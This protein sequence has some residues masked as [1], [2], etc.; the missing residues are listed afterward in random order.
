[1]KPREMPTDPDALL[2]ENEAA[3]L[4]GLSARTLQAWRTAKCGPPYTKL[5]RAIRYV[6]R[7]LIE[8]YDAKARK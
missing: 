4:L 7:W 3:E 5:G 6:R 1:M 8:W 2:T